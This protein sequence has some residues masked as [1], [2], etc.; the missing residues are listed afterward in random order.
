M[1]S[2]SIDNIDV[3]NGE[4]ITQNQRRQEP[5][6]GVEVGKLEE[7]V[8]SKRLQPAGGIAGIVV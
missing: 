2:I 6:H 8:A 3:A 7:N 1:P 5:M 4:P